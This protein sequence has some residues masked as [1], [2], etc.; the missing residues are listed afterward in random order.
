[1]LPEVARVDVVLKSEIH[2]RATDV[3]WHLS[4]DCYFFRGYV[5][6]LME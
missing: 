3:Q 4:A 5:D 6:F 1:M 2:S